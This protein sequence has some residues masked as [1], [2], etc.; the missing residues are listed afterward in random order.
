MSRMGFV[1]KEIKNEIAPIVKE[2]FTNAICYGKTGSG[3]TTGF[4]LPNIENR[5]KSNHGMLIYDFKG[6][7][8]KHIK[9]LA[10]KYDKLDDVY[11]IGKPW[12]KKINLIK[13]INKKTLRS[14]FS[15]LSG[16]TYSLDYWE[17]AAA[18]LLENIYMIHK[19]LSLTLDTI[20]EINS[21]HSEYSIEIKILNQYQVN[22]KSLFQSCNSVGAIVYFLQDT[23]V[24]LNVIENTFVDL[25]ELIST[26]ADIKDLVKTTI[27]Y[28]NKAKTSF[29]ALD[30]YYTM[31]VSKESETGG[32]Y[33]VLNVLNTTLSS[34]ALNEYI[35][36]D[37][38]NI[39]QALRDEKIV[40]VN[41]NDIDNKILGMFN[42]LIYQELQRSILHTTN[43][44]D[45]T[46]FIDEAQ[47]V[48]H[49]EYL[50]DVDVCRESRFEYIFATQ[51]KMLLESTI[52]RYADILL[53]N[54]VEQ[55]SFATND[56]NKLKEF[57]YKNLIL[58]KT[59]YAKPMFL[60]DKEL[61]NIEY[62]YQKQNGIL[63][64]ADLKNTKKQYIVEFVPEYFENGDILVKFKNNKTQIVKYKID[65]DSILQR[66][67]LTISSKD[68][69]SKDLEYD[70][71]KTELNNIMEACNLPT[72]IE[73]NSSVQYNYISQQGTIKEQVAILNQIVNKLLNNEASLKKTISNLTTEL[74]N[75]KNVTAKCAKAITNNIT[76][77]KEIEQKIENV[78][79]KQKQQVSFA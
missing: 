59:Y 39:T 5:M 78:E 32:K 46:I 29:E 43:L 33:G 3:K 19:N 50:P 71:L 69:I 44:S 30:E 45:V 1:T 28:F 55:Y 36:T 4:M 73:N 48:L 38:F 15:N 47:K 37:E 67:M 41:L 60:D 27:R 12:G 21:L 16:D 17:N 24:D 7:L 63:K 68:K 40:I 56:T 20:K 11:E 74:V 58:N 22:L 10:K 23:F 51:D 34:A 49:H 25:T 79:E 18:N 64:Y 9:L 14:L 72:S 57:E 70:E 75:N 66:Y 62:F 52:G 65:D 76:R 53:K 6:N 13:T 8:H 77:L 26:F 31:S 42:L 61:F 2:N 54:V 35:N